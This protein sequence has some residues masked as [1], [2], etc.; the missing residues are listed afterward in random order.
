LHFGLDPAIE[1][2]KRCRM[3]VILGAG[4]N[5]PF[6]DEQFDIILCLTALHNFKDPEKGIIEMKRVGK[7]YWIITVFKRSANVSRTERL[8]QLVKTYFNVEKEL[9]DPHDYIYLCSKMNASSS[10]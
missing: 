8:V 7:K 9:N 10:Y 5:L 6:K 2:L 3:D 4:E 1:L